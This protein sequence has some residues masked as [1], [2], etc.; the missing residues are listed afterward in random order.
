M[1]LKVTRGELEYTFDCQ[2][3]TKLISK[4]A[5]LEDIK[6]EPCG[7]CASTDVKYYAGTSQRGDFQGMLCNGCGARLS[8][9][10]NRNTGSLF[11]ARKDRNGG[12][13]ANSGWSIWEQREARNDEYSAPAEMGGAALAGD[14]QETIPF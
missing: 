12:V 5:L 3:P 13:A 2:T 11:K 14:R 9:M 6:L 1:Q 4:L 8:L 10:A 7:C